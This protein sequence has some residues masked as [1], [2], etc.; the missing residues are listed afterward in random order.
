MIYEIENKDR[1]ATLFAGWEDGLILSCLQGHM[2]KAYADDCDE[3]NSAMIIVDVFCFFSGVVNEEL[4]ASCVKKTD[5]NFLILNVQNEEWAKSIEQLHQ[6]AQKRQRYAI[7]KELS[8][9]RQEILLQYTQEIPAQY[10]LH[11]IN[12]ELYDQIMQEEWSMDLCAAFKDKSDFLEHGLGVIAMKGNAIDSGASSY[13]YYDQG[14]EI[15]IDTRKEERRKG[16]ALA[17]G[18][19]L[20]LECLKR[21]WYPSWD[22]QNTASVALAEKLG[23]HYDA[24]YDVYELHF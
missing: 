5:K 22:A 12:S 24:T 9:F 10:Q 21:N 2:G 14:I 23:Y 13:V 4:L 11:T 8:V 3:P 20:I 16:L 19:A 6:T 7:K 18:A 17:C 15:E 1:I